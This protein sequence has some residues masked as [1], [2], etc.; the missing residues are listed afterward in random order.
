MRVRTAAHAAVTSG[1]LAR[2]SGRPTRL[3]I[4]AMIG[5]RS[6]SH[7]HES[8]S[9]NEVFELSISAIQPD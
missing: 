7:Q 9:C 2:I 8:C 1:E 3:L 6:I 5:G 4:F